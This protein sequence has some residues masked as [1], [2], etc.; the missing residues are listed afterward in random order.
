MAVS[1]TAAV[2]ICAAMPWADSPLLLFVAF[3]V[4]AWAP[5]G[6]I[7][8]LVSETLRADNRALGM[9]LFYTWYYAGMGALPPLAGLARDLS[10][11]P[12]A[13]VYFAGAMMLCALACVGLFRLHRRAV[14]TASA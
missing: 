12:A 9:G 5:A 14:A 7:I 3:G 1:L 4:L 2:A 11:S 10:G 8:A 13:P 6:P